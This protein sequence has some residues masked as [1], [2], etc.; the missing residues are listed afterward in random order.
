MINRYLGIAGIFLC[1]AAYFWGYSAGKKKVETK[2][3]E[4]VVYVQQKS[5][6]NTIYNKVLADKIKQQIEE[7]RDVSEDCA[8]VLDFDLSKC[9]H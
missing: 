3:V 1:C 7:G 8:F 2:I 6:T 9:L 4:K 5:I